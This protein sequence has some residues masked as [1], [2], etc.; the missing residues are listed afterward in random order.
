MKRINKEV[1]KRNLKLEN[2]C[3]IGNDITDLECI[4]KAG[5]RVAVTDSHEAAI[6]VV[7]YITKKKGGECV[8]REVADLVLSNRQEF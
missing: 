6:K 5:I 8:V 3:F 4:K 7:D 2:V 1:K